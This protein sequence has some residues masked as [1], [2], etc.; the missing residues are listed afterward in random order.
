M[1]FD[2]VAPH[3]D[4]LIDVFYARLL[5]P[6]AALGTLPAAAVTAHSTS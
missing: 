3:G 6:R 2:L 1:S 4:E 5:A